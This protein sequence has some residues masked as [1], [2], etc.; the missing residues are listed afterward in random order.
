MRA[1]RFPTPVRA[2]VRYL[3]LDDR[4]TLLGAPIPD[5]RVLRP[6]ARALQAPHLPGLRLRGAQ[7][8]RRHLQPAEVGRALRPLLGMLRGPEVPALQRLLLRGDR[9]LHR[10]RN[11]ALRAGRR[12]RI[13]M[14][15]RLR[16]RPHPQH[17]LS[18]RTRAAQARSRTFSR[19]SG[20]R[21]RPGSRKATNAANS[22]R[23]R[24]PTP[25]SLS[26]RVRRRAT[27]T[28]SSRAVPPRRPPVRAARGRFSRARPTP[29]CRRLPA[30]E[31]AAPT[32]SPVPRTIPP[33]R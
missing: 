29:S 1:T 14:A 22:R 9:T 25:S 28:R 4:E 11:R 32:A 26:R 33:R 30:H 6:D 3:S 8:N 24:P 7:V 18:S 27:S 12:R 19:A 20:A 13:Q 15:A 17:A 2:D 5:A 21:S 31:N 16:S 23:R 10:E